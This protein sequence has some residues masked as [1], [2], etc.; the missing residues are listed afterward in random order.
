M[1]LITIKATSILVYYAVSIQIVSTY[2]RVYNF[3]L[4]NIIDL[5]RW[6]VYIYYSPSASVLNHFQ[7]LSHFNNV[8]F[9]NKLHIIFNEFAK[10]KTEINRYTQRFFHVQ[11]LKTFKIFVVAIFRRLNKKIEIVFKK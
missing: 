3:Y 4:R 7:F 6:L 9:S 2:I 11:I 8:F 5:S 10:F 1:E